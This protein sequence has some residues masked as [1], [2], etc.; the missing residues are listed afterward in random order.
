VSAVLP[1]GVD[2]LQDV[3]FPLF[4]A[5]RLALGFLNFDELPKDERP[6]RRIWLDHDAMS[7]HWA[8]VER[9]RKEKYEGDGGDGGDYEENAAAKDLIQ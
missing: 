4:D 2:K 9:R 6:P 1:E 8:A 5:I 3:P 7:A